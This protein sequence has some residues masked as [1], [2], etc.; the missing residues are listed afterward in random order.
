MKRFEGIFLDFYGTVAGGDRQAVH[1]VCRA[2]IDDYGLA[3]D[4]GDLASRWGDQYFAVIEAMD[5]RQFRLLRAIEGETLIETVRPLGVEIDA[6]PYVEQ[7]N[8]YLACPT[9]Y[10]EAH[11][12]LAALRL[13][14][15]IVS[16]ADER[17]IRLAIAHHGLD[18]GYLVTSESAR[19]Y[20]PE[21][22]IF[23]AALE[24][25]G[26]PADRVLHVGDSLHSDVGGAH[27]AGLKAAWVRRSVR[28]KDIGT[29][30]PEYT[31]DDLRP[32]LTI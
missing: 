23:R 14:V 20:K 32:L 24:L 3:A 8:A 17:E 11:E 6:L 29:D 19:S 9:L 18:F 28:I 13:P 12:V 30:Q 25:T 22:G 15:C 16:N 31:W 7:L 4:A 27:N 26:W 2:V 1:D 21:P 10:D 5:G